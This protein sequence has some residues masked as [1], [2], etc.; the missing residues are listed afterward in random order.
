MVKI[1]QFPC[2]DPLCCNREGDK[3][4][5]LSFFIPSFFPDNLSSRDLEKSRS[6]IPVFNNRDDCQS[7]QHPFFS[8]SSQTNKP[9][10]SSKDGSDD[11]GDQEG[12]RSASREETGGAPG[13][14]TRTWARHDVILGVGAAGRNSGGGDLDRLS[15]DGGRDGETEVRV[16]AEGGGLNGGEGAP[17]VD[18]VAAA[19]GP[20]GDGE[21]IGAVLP[22]AGS[23]C[24][25]PSAG[26]DVDEGL[27]V[28]DAEHEAG[29]VAVAAPDL[30]LQGV[31][32]AVGRE[33][34]VRVRGSTVGGAVQRGQGGAACAGAQVG[35]GRGH[36]VGDD[37][38]NTAGE[39]ALREGALAEKVLELGLTV[40]THREV[41]MGACKPEI[42][43]II[44]K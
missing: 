28:G 22:G 6:P 14:S 20:A 21:A 2:Q 42:I 13:G 34:K 10:G 15:D 29:A 44:K 9:P 16:G 27:A 32:V 24:V 19:V 23:G 4:G 38:V 36:G 39:A 7:R 30:G 8:L 26:A 5:F 17:A 12:E 11:D 37:I 1:A 18:G 3:N 43:I 31:E 41:V 40:S 33:V 35:T 25:G